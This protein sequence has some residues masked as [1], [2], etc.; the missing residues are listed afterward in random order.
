MSFWGSNWRISSRRFEC[1]ETFTNWNSQWWNFRWLL[2]SR[3][4]WSAAWNIIL[5]LELLARWE[6]LLRLCCQP[7]SGYRIL[8]QV[9][10]TSL[11]A[12]AAPESKV[13][14]KRFIVSLIWLTPFLW[15]MASLYFLWS[16]FPELRTFISQ[17]KVHF[18]RDYFKTSQI[19]P[20]V[21]STNTFA[22]NFFRQ[23]FYSRFVTNW[24]ARVNFEKMNFWI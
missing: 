1:G 3:C 14:N 5:Y 4:W 18:V 23:I 16:S 15:L 6:E 19:D 17:I 2:R 24:K 8:L 9:R 13:I 12:T 11:N 10:R 22:V 21:E 20:N 7:M